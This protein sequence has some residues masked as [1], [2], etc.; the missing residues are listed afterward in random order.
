MRPSAWDWG[1]AS[2]P[3]PAAAVRAVAPGAGK[4][5]SQHRG[6]EMVGLQKAL[7]TAGVPTADPG[8][9]AQVHPKRA[10]DGLIRRLR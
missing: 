8:P 1:G 3:D 4:T 6:F 5:F 2:C 7:D 9:F 10:A